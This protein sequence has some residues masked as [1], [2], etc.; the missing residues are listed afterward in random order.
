M[1]DTQ[2]K[3]FYI[4]SIMAAKKEQAYK[5][6]I[7]FYFHN[8]EWSE[9]VLDEYAGVNIAADGSEEFFIGDIILVRFGPLQTNTVIEDGKVMCLYSQKI[10]VLY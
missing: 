8:E 6:A 3:A 9:D 2:E 5:N 10:I 4:A 7:N 1:N